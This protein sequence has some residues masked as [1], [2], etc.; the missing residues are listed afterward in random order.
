MI[1]ELQTTRPALAF[2]EIPQLYRYLVASLGEISSRSVG[3]IEKA[4]DG[5]TPPRRAYGIAAAVKEAVVRIEAAR[6]T[7]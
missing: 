3:V 6:S 1:A 5:G 7:G 2:D 4:L